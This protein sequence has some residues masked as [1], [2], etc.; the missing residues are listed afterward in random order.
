MEQIATEMHY[1]LIKTIYF[2]LLHKKFDFRIII[3]CQI[4]MTAIAKS[5][6]GR[7]A[8]IRSY[9]FSAPVCSKLTINEG[10]LL[11]FSTGPFLGERV[12]YIRLGKQTGGVG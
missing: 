1:L 3:A 12:K 2:P 6:N 10:S 8:L 11:V 7:H 5:C 9:G 4:N